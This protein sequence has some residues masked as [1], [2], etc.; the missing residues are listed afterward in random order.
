MQSGV[1]ALAS[2]E[3]EPL[4]QAL[5]E[6]AATAPQSDTTGTES[7]GEAD[8]GLD[9]T[10]P[11]S[12]PANS[13]DGTDAALPED[14]GAGDTPALESGST[15][16]PSASGDG[17]PAT[18]ESA[19]TPGS[20][21]TL[22]DDDSAAGTS[23]PPEPGESEES[24]E[25]TGE[26]AELVVPQAAPVLTALRFYFL[27]EL[28][29]EIPAVPPQPAIPATY[30][31]VACDTQASPPVV[32]RIETPLGAVELGAWLLYSDGSTRLPE[33]LPVTLSWELTGFEDAKG[34]TLATALAE[35]DRDTATVTALGTGNGTA[36]LTCSIT[37]S[38]E[39][40]LPVLA[41]Q[42]LRV[43]IS[44]NSSGETLTLTSYKLLYRNPATG[45]QPSYYNPVAGVPATITTRGGSLALSVRVVW[46]DGSE[47]SAEAAGAV[48]TWNLLTGGDIAS[49]SAEGL[50][51]ALASKNGIVTLQCTPQNLALVS[52]QTMTVEVQGNGPPPV[53]QPVELYLLYTD[54][55]TPV[56]L[57]YDA[58][59]NKIPIIS[60]ERGTAQLL[61]R[62]F[63]ESNSQPGIS[64]G[65]PSEQGWAVSWQVTST[66]DLSDNPLSTVL[67]Y[68]EDDGR[69]TATGFGNGW[70][71]VRMSLPQY[72]G[73][74]AV[75]ARVKI[76]GNTATL[77]WMEIVD[78]NGTPYPGNSYDIKPSKLPAEEF[79]VNAH[80]TDS[81]V[82]RT[83]AGDKIEGLKWSV[84]DTE[85]A[86]IDETL[87]MFT[88][89]QGFE[90]VTV[91][92]SVAKAGFSGEEIYATLLVYDS[93][94]QDD[95]TDLHSDSLHVRVFYDS[96]FRAKGN[97]ATPVAEKSL[98]IDYILQN[99][100]IYTNE[101]TYCRWDT[102]I[103]RP[104]HWG[105]MAARGF[106]F[107][108]LASDLGV[109]INDVTGAR[110]NMKQSINLS[111]VSS[112]ILFAT[113]YRYPNY[114][115]SANYGNPGTSFATVVE[116]MLAL[117]TCR[118]NEENTALGSPMIQS[119]RFRLCVGMYHS[120]DNNDAN[121]YK[122]VYGV[123]FIIQDDAIVLD[124]NEQKE[125]DLKE[126]PREPQR[127]PGGEGDFFGG[128]GEGGGLG[129]G[130][131]NLPGEAVTGTEGS[132]EG[133]DASDSSSAKGAE[134]GGG[135]T[136]ERSYSIHQVLSNSQTYF[137]RD[138]GANP[139]MPVG[140][141]AGALALCAGALKAGMVFVGQ[142]RR[143][144][145]D[146][147]HD[148]D[149][150]TG[151]AAAGAP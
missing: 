81:T 82:K 71:S 8:A 32:P 15:D 37:A 76:T 65:D 22:T 42:E 18:G 142:K 46:S 57:P 24:R 16:L 111:V 136:A 146:N 100:A 77:A 88:T 126:E 78:A 45:E 137:A 17:Q 12:G 86:A 36:L 108:T 9:S 23:E 115:P 59:N 85:Q 80:Y 84:S 40:G 109:H 20:D 10:A 6:Q 7:P 64:A 95:A 79:Y 50:V 93:S 72:P 14:G 129:G 68:I 128:T 74:A 83:W 52:P 145:A 58:R 61:P 138:D 38:S 27:Q 110:F 98:S 119:A 120:K 91:R 60:S 75:S 144:G 54:S 113:R 118:V 107:P 3:A 116:P 139:L 63:I 127:G 70:I 149:A 141:T 123:D 1:F 97:A 26:A 2:A 43:A 99:F 102:D 92:A 11:D 5:L 124:P 103:D 133:G 147:E 90:Q 105:T 121:S 41:T 28:T 44:G 96:D 150:G 106:N 19:L 135:G 25:A 39:L 87:G 69:V 33:D 130:T 94:G 101:Y 47:Q 140:V 66:T 132:S 131:G 151:A 34:K 104:S 125:E 21:P 4:E 55:N 143:G 35:I 48:F 62:A 73:L 30:E 117:E 51:T 49:V 114:G 148:D 89:R 67:A 53:Y 122:W 13:P 112:D 56:P 29:P 134:A 31:K